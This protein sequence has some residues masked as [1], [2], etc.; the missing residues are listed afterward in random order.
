[1]VMGSEFSARPHSTMLT[2]VMASTAVSVF[3]PPQWSD[4]QPP[5][6]RRAAPRKAASMV[7]WPACTLLT[8]NWS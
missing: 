8:W 1:M 3:T 5:K 6:M 2:A 7:S 4:S